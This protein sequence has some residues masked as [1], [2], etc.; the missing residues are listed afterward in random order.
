[1]TGTVA[2]LP[3]VNVAVYK[4]VPLTDLGRRR[5]ELREFCNMR[6]LKGTILLST[7]GINLF[8]AGLED[9]V[10]CLL[11]KLESDPEVGHL[12]VK[13]SR[14]AEVPFRRML[15]KVKR[16]IISF[17]VPGVDPLSQR[18]PKVSA[19]ELKRWIDEGRDITLLDVRND[20]EVQLGTFAGAEAIGVDNFRSFPDAV[21][22]LPETMKSRTIVMFCT[23]GI[24]CE[25]AGPMM[26]QAGF[27][28]VVQ[29]DG[30]IL[31]YFEECGGE[32]YQGECFVFDQRVSVDHQLRETETAQCFACQATLTVEDQQSAKYLPGESC[33]HCYRS[34]VDKMRENIAAREQRIHEVAT[35]LPGSVPYENRRPLNVPGRCDG[36]KLVDMLASMHPHVTQEEWLSWCEDGQIRRDEER[37]QPDSIVVAG[38]RIERVEAETVE[39]DVN[40]DIRILY[41]DA[42]LV[43][44]QK[45]APLPMHPSGRFNRNTLAYILDE[46]YSPQRLRIVHRLDAN[47]TGVVVMARTRNVARRL[48]PQFEQCKVNKL[49]VARIHGTP[50]QDEFSCDAPI[51]LRP[52]KSGSRQADV[53]GRASRTEFRF[54][55][56]LEDGT[57]LVSARPVTG[58]TN[59]IRLHLA[60]LGFPIVGDPTY[61][62]EGL[63]NRQTLSVDDEPLCLHARRIGLNHPENKAWVEFVAELPEWAE[64]L[65]GQDV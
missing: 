7:E 33:P 60:H 37:M 9:D 25:K 53:G 35:P 15:V 39:P 50:E 4:F 27:E 30:G 10:A 57:S 61:R 48:Q 18:S 17:D 49:Y 45:P 59:Q 44:V 5:R 43:V 19:T 8:V 47:T 6:R 29:L 41:E 42:M 51:S 22:E 46:A 55:H 14:S 26:E 28:N 40:A 23:G 3:I 2:D 21:R 36:F 1:M 64:E 31:K 38:Q 54:L 13:R 58:R 20:Y 65:R 11:E 52:G 16:E 63:G 24:R 34:S 12:E 62:R 32:H 56:S